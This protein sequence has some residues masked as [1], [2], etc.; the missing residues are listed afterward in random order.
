M[1][2]TCCMLERIFVIARSF[3]SFGVKKK[4]CKPHNSL[5]YTF[6]AERGGFEPPIP[7]RGIHAF[8]ACL[9]NHSSIFP[10]ASEKLSFV[11]RTQNDLQK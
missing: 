11:F 8:Q 9:F 2:N 3:P 10:K 1:E 6:L 7:F 4:K 5:V